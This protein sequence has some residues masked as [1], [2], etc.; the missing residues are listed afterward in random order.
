MKDAFKV[1]I[2][3]LEKTRTYFEELK[4]VLR[5]AA[6]ECEAV[7][8]FCGSAYRN[9]GAAKTFTITDICRYDNPKS[10]DGFKTKA[11]SF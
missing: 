5:K 11:K 1:S 2:N 4:K 8:V 3:D 9:K 7:P 6:C 10:I